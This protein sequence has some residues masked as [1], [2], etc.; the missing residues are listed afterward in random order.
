MWNGFLTIFPLLSVVSSSLFLFLLFDDYFL[1]LFEG[2]AEALE[3]RIIGEKTQ[4]QMRYITIGHDV[5]R[6][7]SAHFADAD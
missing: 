6:A 1:N 4:M 2:F 5:S 7:Y 3:A